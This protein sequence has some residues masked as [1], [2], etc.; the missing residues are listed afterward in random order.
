MSKVQEYKYI[1]LYINDDLPIQWKFI[2][3]KDIEM[4]IQREKKSKYRL[5]IYKISRDNV[6][7][8]PAFTKKHFRMFS[9]T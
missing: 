4:E 5:K 2:D 9:V 1:A 7:H 8:D 3:H 6:I